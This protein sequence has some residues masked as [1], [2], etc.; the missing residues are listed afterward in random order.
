[1]KITSLD[2]MPVEALDRFLS[3]FVTGGKDECW[4]WLGT[5]HH[6]GYGVMQITIGGNR[7]QYR[8][9]QLAHIVGGGTLPT[10]GRLLMH[11]CDVKR[12][13]NPKHIAPGTVLQNNR[14]AVA[15]LGADQG[16]NHGNHIL[17]DAEVIEIRRLRRVGVPTKEIAETFGVSVANIYDVTLRSWKHIPNTYVMETSPCP[18]C[19]HP[20]MLR[21]PQRDRH[22]RACKGYQTTDRAGFLRRQEAKKKAVN[23]LL[24]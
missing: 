12:C 6:T 3:K 7:M 1:M 22:I 11:S 21:Q 2:Q 17:T 10:D 4:L 13:V 14:D 5:M 24:L 18:K 15:R 19:G 8:A 23:V 9:H 16:M 20:F